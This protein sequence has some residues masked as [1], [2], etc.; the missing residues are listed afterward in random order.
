MK[1]Q[2]FQGDANISQWFDICNKLVLPITLLL[3][4]S[5]RS[6]AG[7]AHTVAH[8]KPTSWETKEPESAQGHLQGIVFHTAVNHL[9]N[10]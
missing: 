8:T 6:F 4:P 5:A 7:H 1:N 2:H 9:G 3:L 10:S